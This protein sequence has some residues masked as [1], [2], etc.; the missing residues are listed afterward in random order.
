VTSGPSSAATLTP[1]EFPALINEPKY[2]PLQYI[3]MEMKVNGKFK[4]HRGLV[5]GGSQSNRIQRDFSQNHVPTTQKPKS[6]P[7]TMIMADGNKSHTGPVTHY[8]DTTVRIAGHEEKLA[9]DV[10]SLSHP[11][12]LGMPWLW[13]HNPLIDY[14]ADTMTFRSKFWRQN[15]THYNKTITLHPTD[16]AQEQAQDQDQDQDQAQ[17]APHEGVVPRGDAMP[18]GYERL[19]QE[20]SPDT[21]LLVQKDR[22]APQVALIGAAAFAQGCNQPGTELFFLSIEKLQGAQLSHQEVEVVTETPEFDLSTIPPKYHKFVDLFSKR[23]A[24]KLPPHRPYDHRIPLE[25]NTTPPFGTIY[26]MSPVELEAARKYIEENLHKV[27]IRHSQSQCS[28][29]I[30]L[31]KKGDG[32]LRLCVNYRGLNKLTIKNRY[33][34]PFNGEL[35]ERMNNAKY[36]TKF[37]VRDGYNR[38]RVASGEE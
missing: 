6:L 35:L 33:P 16:Q 30:I 27:F 7:T 34:L 29:P 15:C 13:E 12:L 14:H 25:P 8:N 1:P 23:K 3:E 2:A 31:A 24:D 28:A 18:R 9:L 5:D 20:I 17:G 37:E 11:L 38:L 4:K 10:T 19:D 36:F 26:K 22:K 21:P 32:M